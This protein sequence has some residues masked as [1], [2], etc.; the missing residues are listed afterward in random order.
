MTTVTM[1][2]TT[3]SPTKLKI[4]LVGSM[5]TAESIST[6]IKKVTSLQ[7]SKAGPFHV[8]F[9]VGPVETEQLLQQLSVLSSDV[10]PL[11][12]YLQDYNSAATI[13]ATATTMSDGTMALGQNVFAFPTDKIF[14]NLSIQQQSLIVCV[15]SFHY[16]GNHSNNTNNSNNNNQI[17]DD[18]DLISH[19]CDFLLSSEWPQGIES[20]LATT[21]TENNASSSTPATSNPAAN[22]SFDVAQ[23]ALLTRPRY[24]VAPCPWQFTTSL[25]FHQSSSTTTNTL[26]A[27]TTPNNNNISTGRFIGMA[28]VSIHPP[29]GTNK[30]IHA[31]G[32]E[33][34]TTTMKKQ[35]NYDTTTTTGV[36]PNPYT[37]LFSMEQPI[38][39]GASVGV[40]ISQTQMNRIIG[41]GTTNQHYDHR[42]SNNS[43][44]KRPAFQQQNDESSSND[45]L[46]L[47]CTTLFIHGLH[48]DVTNKLQTG[49]SELLQAFAPYHVVKVRRPNASITATTSSYAFLEFKTHEDAE[50]CLQSLAGEITIQGVHLTLKWATTNN[51]SHHFQNTNYYSSNPHKR[52]RLTE[53]EAKS[54][55]TLYFKLPSR[56]LTDDIVMVTEQLRRFME[57]T[58]EKALG[59]PTITAAT[60]P[61]LQVKSRIIGTTTTTSGN[62]TADV[63][64]KNF[65]FLE[66]ASHAAA[67][68]VLATGTGST[69]GGILTTTEDNSVPEEFW[70]VLL[71]WAPSDNKSKEQ[72]TST[73]TTASG[74][75]FSRQHFPID[76]RSDCWF[77]LAS[78]GCEKHLITAVFQQCYLAMPKGPI[79]PGH[80]L[81]VPVKHTSKGALSDTSLQHEISDLKQRLYRHAK[82][83]YQCELFVWERAIQ[84]KGGYHTHLQCVPV[85]SDKVVQLCKTIVE[86]ARTSGF[87]LRELNSDLGLQ[88][89]SDM[90]EHEGYFYAELLLARDSKRWL[91][92]AV[93]SRTSS[94]VPL[95]FGREVLAVV[96]NQPDLAHWKACV[97]EKD[98]EQ[99][100]ALDFRKSFEKYEPN[101]DK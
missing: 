69:D 1:T 89:L 21:T 72:T 78:Q 55:S 12:M 29:K 100:L 43:N 9:I 75:A 80:V 37:N 90:E 14:Y 38:T 26:T 10:V 54:S 48:K 98:K 42:W 7:K 64:T 60:E 33:P 47:S 15:L 20:I 49:S 50:H 59:D 3:G 5:D 18:N 44:N 17:H 84:T 40:G 45:D 34:L 16:L 46:I 31:L 99:E 88:A 65:G 27:T 52:Q 92:Q 77:C 35:Q 53:Q 6:F 67:S 94:R 57:T 82:E 76:A 25:P 66:F 61:A 23:V 86:L 96:M 8:C 93:A 13:T 24:H 71:Y 11:P 87:V 62:S 51:H 32:L 95:Q 101:D 70:G 2:A 63:T 28:N 79:H 81:I 56:V 97:L 83:M 30:W 22:I 73:M 58:L 41:D 68:M 36:V 39:R 74:V 4:L 19:G 91:H 85:L